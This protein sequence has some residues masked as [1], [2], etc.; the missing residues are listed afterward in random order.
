L[1]R[2]SYPRRRQPRPGFFFPLAV[3]ALLASL[4]LAAVALG[5]WMVGAIEGAGPTPTPT[6][7]PTPKPLPACE[8]ADVPAVY[9]SYDDWARTLLDTSFMLD[10]GYVPPDLVPV[11]EAGVGGSG[12][13]RS[14]VIPDLQALV[15]AAR[16]DGLDPRVNSAYRSFDDQASLYAD[17]VRQ[18]GKEWALSS[19]AQAGHSEHQL[20]TAIDFGGAMGAW[21]VANAWQYGFVSSYPDDASQPKTCFKGE[22]WHVRYVGRATAEAIHAS[23]LT[24]RE[25]LWVKT[26]AG[27][28]VAATP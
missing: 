17:T 14:F 12:E 8:F 3:G 21:L 7:T 26:L 24:A 15:S 27:P 9:V 20:G 16:A 4:A 1:T 13:V 28:Q 22:T 2:Y 25:W 5:P 6:P 23:G 18:Y 11:S 19:A 10:A